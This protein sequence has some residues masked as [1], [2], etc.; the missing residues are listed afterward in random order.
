MKNRDQYENLDQYEH[1]RVNGV[2]V[3]GVSLRVTHEIGELTGTESMKR[4]SPQMV[5]G[6]ILH[7][8]IFGQCQGT[9]DNAKEQRRQRTTANDNGK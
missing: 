7:T 6:W 3:N 4:N 2:R 5:D 1:I 8:L 9:M